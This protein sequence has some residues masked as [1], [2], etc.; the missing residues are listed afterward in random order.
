MTYRAC[1]VIACVLMISGCGVQ[2][3]RSW[4]LMP[5]DSGR[6]PR[7]KRAWVAPVEVTDPAISDRRTAEQQ[8]GLSI[9]DYLRLGRYFSDVAGSSDPVRPEDLVLRFR[10]E[11]YRYTRS[12]HPL[13]IP[14]ALATL[15]FYFWV[16]GPV[17]TEA[18]DLVLTLAV[19]DS[20]GTVLTTVTS[21]VDEQRNVSIYSK[22]AV[23]EDPTYETSQA[24]TRLVKQ[25]LDD[26]S[27]RMRQ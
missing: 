14:A 19:E 15:T 24:L 11:R 23:V 3:R 6:A 9:R 7:P 21:R 2:Y 22:R 27:A 17:A 25:A 20:K 8:L 1:A 4:T 13:A 26:M 10:I 5:P 16:G 18:K 12:A